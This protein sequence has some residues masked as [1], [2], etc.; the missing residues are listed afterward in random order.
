MAA[1]D[2]TSPR[3]VQ[4]GAFNSGASENMASDLDARSTGKL[5][6]IWGWNMAIKNNKILHPKLGI[7]TNQNMIQ[8]HS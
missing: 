8:N 3:G 6:E 5:H 7:G 2:L 4:L 1:S